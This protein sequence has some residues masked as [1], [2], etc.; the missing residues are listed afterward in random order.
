MK[1]KRF[2]PSW[3]CCE[4]DRGASFFLALFRHI[5]FSFLCLVGFFFALVTVGECTVSFVFCVVVVPGSLKE[6]CKSS[7]SVN[8]P[9]TSVPSVIS[10]VRF[11]SSQAGSELCVVGGYHDLA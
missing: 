8:T 9:E 7:K 10:T 2:I 4:L 5:Y 6:L 11:P 1:W 3:T